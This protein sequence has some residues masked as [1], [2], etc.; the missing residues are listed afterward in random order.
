MVPILCGCFLFESEL[1]FSFRVVVSYDAY[2]EV[3][4]ENRANPRSF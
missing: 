3:F 4:F 1:V 2:M